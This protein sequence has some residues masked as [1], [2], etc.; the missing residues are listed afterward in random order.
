MYKY[1]EF[2][3]ERERERE[4]EREDGERGR[5]RFCVLH[6]QRGANFEFS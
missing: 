2:E 5:E 1:T 6:K 3:T 4:R